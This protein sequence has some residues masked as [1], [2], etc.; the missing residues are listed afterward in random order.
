[1][2]RKFKHAKAFGVIDNFNMENLTLFKEAIISHMKNPSTEFI[3]GFWKVNPVDHYSNSN[4]GL[5]V[6]FTHQTKNFISGWRL[7]KKE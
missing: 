7:N 3:Q 5:N 1:M 4:N 6:I 2:Y